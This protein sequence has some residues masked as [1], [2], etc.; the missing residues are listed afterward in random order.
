MKGCRVALFVVLVVAPGSGVAQGA[1][2]KAT[3]PEFGGP[4]VRLPS[5]GPQFAQLRQ[6]PSPSVVERE[7]Q[8]L[9]EAGIPVPSLPALLQWIPQTERMPERQ[10]ISFRR[11]ACRHWAVSRRSEGS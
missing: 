9:V 1:W 4:Q 10:K 8:R 5:F 11:N 7:R 6:T 2:P 3:A